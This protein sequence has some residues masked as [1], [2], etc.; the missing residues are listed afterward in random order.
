MHGSVELHQHHPPKYSGTRA[1]TFEL[2]KGAQVFK[3]RVSKLK[4][5][6]YIFMFEARN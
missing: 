6:D 4:A 1:L 5:D 3:L 2:I